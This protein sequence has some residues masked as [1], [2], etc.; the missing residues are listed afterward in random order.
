MIMMVTS[1]C[2]KLIVISRIFL[3][4]FFFSQQNGRAGGI[5]D[6]ADNRAP[7]IG[8]IAAAAVAFEIQSGIVCVF[9]ITWDFDNR[10][11]QRIIRR[12]SVFS[13][14]REDETLK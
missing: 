11:Q 2:W 6:A 14:Y 5:I 4:F 10:V 13:I 8:T 3:F 7:K 12:V 1:V 9:Y